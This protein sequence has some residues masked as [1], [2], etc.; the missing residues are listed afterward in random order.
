VA[1][2]E[3]LIHRAIESNLSIAQIDSISA[4]SHLPRND[5]YNELALIIARRFISGSMSFEDAD[6][7]INSIWSLMI[8][9]TENDACLAE[10]AYSIYQAFDGGE[11][12]HRD[13]DDPIEKFTKPRTAEL[14]SE[15]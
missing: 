11:Y 5:L 1:D 8:M 3:Q 6:L 10:P 14:L 7:A 15:V 9:N 12:D 13:G 4:S 2:F